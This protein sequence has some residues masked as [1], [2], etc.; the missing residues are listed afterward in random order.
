MK[1]DN[2][3]RRLDLARIALNDSISQWS[4]DYWTNVLSYLL[5]SANRTN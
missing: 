5:R 2:I 1:I 4:I 3:E